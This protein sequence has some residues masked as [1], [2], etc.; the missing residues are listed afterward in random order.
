MANILIIDDE[1]IALIALQEELERAG[2]SC[3]VALNGDEGIELVKK[4]MFDIV[5]TDL[6]M[7]GKNGVEVCKE[8]KKIS[9]DTEIVLISGYAKKVLMLKH[10][11]IQAGGNIEILVKPLPEDKLI[12]K[13]EKILREKNLLSA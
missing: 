12:K 11:F 3:K 9:P 5:Y 1:K 8:I 13:T 10:D 2:Y 7:P 6:I 4:E